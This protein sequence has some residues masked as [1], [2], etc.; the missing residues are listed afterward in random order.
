MLGHHY[1]DDLFNPESIAIIGAS[2]RAGSV[3][4]KV[5]SNLRHSHF[6]GKL[7]PVNLKHKRVQGMKCYLAVTDIREPVDLAIITTPAATVL[8]IIKQC[9]EKGIRSA[10]I[11]SAG[12]SEMGDAGKALE[13]SILETAR[14]YNLHFIGPN[15]LGVMRPQSHLNATFD[16]NFALPGNIALVSQSGAI[17]AAILD[18]AVEKK[19][20]FSTIVSTGNSMDLDFGDILDYLALDSATKSILLYIEGVHYPRRFMSG[21]RAA[22]RIKPVI[23]IK[24]GRNP[25]GVRAVHSHTGA[26]VGSDAVFSAALSRGGAVRVMSIE[27]LFSAAQIL[28]SSF[29]VTGNRLLVVTNGGGAGVMAADRATELNIELPQLDKEIVTKLNKVL[30]PQWSH[31]NPIDILGDAKPDRYSS[32]IQ[33]CLQDEASDALLA[34][35]VPVAMSQPYQVAQEI[36]KFAK[37]T[38][39]PLITCFMGEKQTKKSRK[40][41]ADCKIPCYRTPEVAVEAF[42][43]L[44]SYHQNQQMLLQMPEPSISSPKVDIKG[45]EF[46]IN[47]ALAAQR[48]V[49]TTIES[50]AILRTFGIPVSQTIEVHDANEALIVAESLG[51]PIAM[52]ISSPDITHKQD[53]DGVQLNISNGE[54][55]RT[56]FKEMLEKVKIRRPDAKISGVTLERMYKNSHYREVMI[57]VLRDKV[58]GPAISFGL[59]GSLVEII[60]DRAVAL[61]PLNSFLA[62]QMLAKTRA[63]KLLGEFRGKPA[64]DKQALI[65]ILLRISDMV[66][67]LP[68]IQEMDLN[69][70]LVDEKG[71][72]AVD[73]RIVVEYPSISF[74]SYGHMAIHPY[75]IDLVNQWQTPDG[76]PIIIRPIRPEDALAEQEFVGNLSPQAKYFRFM[77]EV[78]ELTPETLVRFT[79]IDYEREMALVA[80]L[81]KRQTETIIGVAR[82]YTQA[83]FSSCEFALAVADAWQNKGIG[84]HLMMALMEAAKAKGIKTMAGRILSD[85]STMLELVSHLGFTTR[86]GEDA[87]IKLAVKELV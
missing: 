59:G 51:F 60:Q 70:V 25:S 24:A 23:A 26:L 35:L 71:A 17:C 79:Q 46:I 21:L 15:C 81:K 64:V 44:V 30:P 38:K 37:E 18:W 55:V 82:Y 66:S 53:V 85:N 11:I 22:A 4:R 20:G 62:E 76:T 10:I 33:T 84:S 47:A 80:T 14:R 9:G 43:Y 63:M 72:I 13:Q 28:S 49:L 41:L 61:P 78:T 56:A 45:A 31:E 87:T 7:F 52:K 1:L 74:S 34:M 77:H 83:D 27:Q 32:V 3:G 75:P 8:D 16:N 5:L 12:F 42:S 69:P 39:K 57:G 68:Q 29:R 6:A 48:K 50:K 58:F 65:H 67:E 86:P 40:L 2:D 36:C 19:I 73:A 54:A